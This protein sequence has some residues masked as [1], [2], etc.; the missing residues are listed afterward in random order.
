M[1][2]RG[3]LYASAVVTGW[4]AVLATVML[5]SDRAPA[6]V[7]MLP[8][9]A[10]LNALPA[11][12]AIVAQNAISVTV[13]GAEGD[14]AARLY[15]AGARLVLPSGLQGCAPPATTGRSHPTRQIVSITPP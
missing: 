13:I 15:R 4:L 9:A 6:A 8:D 5:V 14:V 11:D 3:L 7:V 2:I 12:V 10:F 1:I